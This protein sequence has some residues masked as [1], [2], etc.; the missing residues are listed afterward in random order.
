MAVI[1]VL[2]VVLWRRDLWPLWVILSGPLA[3]AWIG[4]RMGGRGVLGGTLG[5][6]LSWPGLI[7]AIYTYH[8]GVHG[9]VQG[10]FVGPVLSVAITMYGGAVLGFVVGLCVWAF[11]PERRVTYTS[12][13]PPSRG[14]P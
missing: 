7:V 1:A 5:G 8:Y 11:A 14:R 3:G 4:R 12:G 2:A 10:D 9:G 6:M 13:S